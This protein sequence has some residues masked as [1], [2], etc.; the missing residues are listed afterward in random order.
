M[1]SDSVPG[2]TKSPGAN[3]PSRVD[4]LEVVGFVIAEEPAKPVTLTVYGLTVLL[5]RRH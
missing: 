1:N 4:Y 5:A 2:S 3:V